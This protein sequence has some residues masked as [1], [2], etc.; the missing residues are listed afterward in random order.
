M[1][2]N[3]SEF[4]RRYYSSFTLEYEELVHKVF[5]LKILLIAS[6]I[7]LSISLLFNYLF[8]ILWLKN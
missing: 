3:D 6:I 8:F 7:L 4:L 1:K 5:N 2:K